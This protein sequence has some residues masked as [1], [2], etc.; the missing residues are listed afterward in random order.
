MSY[1][2][3]TLPEFERE[4]KKIAKKHKGLRSDISNLIDKLEVNPTLGIDL[5]NNF[6]KIRL[7]ISG[8]NKGKSGGARVITYVI[9]E[10]E[11]VLLSGI[12]LKS[13]IE[14]VNIKSLIVRLK[15]EGLI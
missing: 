10:Q 8:T 12:Y 3:K 14:T 7:S 11:V 6:Y 13:E 9:I 2:V 1:R 5:G 15:D 4:I